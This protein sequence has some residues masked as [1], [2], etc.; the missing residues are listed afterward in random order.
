MFEKTQKHF[1]MR[2]KVP[3]LPQRHWLRSP[4][5]NLRPVDGLSSNAGLIVVTL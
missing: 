2:Q 4:P 3:S 1:G 5:P